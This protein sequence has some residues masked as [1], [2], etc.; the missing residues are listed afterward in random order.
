M[1]HLTDEQLVL[2]QGGLAEGDG[3]TPLPEPPLVGSTDA[4]D[5]WDVDEFP[6]DAD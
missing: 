5:P 1:K 2:V 6:W 4:T 3:P